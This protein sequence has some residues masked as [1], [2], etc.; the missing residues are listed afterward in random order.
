MSTVSNH[1]AIKQD[2]LSRWLLTSEEG[3]VVLVFS[4]KWMG[5][6]YLFESFMEDIRQAA[7]TPFVLEYID[8]EEDGEIASQLGV[9]QLPTTVL[10]KTREVVDVLVGPMSRKKLMARITPHF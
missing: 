4:A 3:L 1:N 2:L 9:S 8:V 7:P 10:L 5:S 6:T